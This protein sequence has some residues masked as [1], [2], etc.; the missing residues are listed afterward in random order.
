MKKITISM[1]LVISIMLSL[2]CGVAVAADSSESLQFEAD[3]NISELAASGVEDGSL[4]DPSTGKY[5][6]VRDLRSVYMGTGTPVNNMLDMRL[7]GDNSRILAN[8][9]PEDP[10]GVG[11]GVFF[12]SGFKDNYTTG[13]SISY[14]IIC[15]TK[16]GGNVSNYL[17]LTSTNRSAKG[18]EA[19]ILYYAQN[20]FCFKVFDWAQPEDARWQVDI[21]ASTL[22]SN[23]VRTKTIHGAERQFVT[24]QNTTVQVGTN[25][26]ANYVYLGTQNSYDLIYSY[27]YTATI[28]EQ[29]GQWIGSWGPIVE[30]FQ[31]TYSGTNVM[32]FYQTFLR[33]S[34]NGTWTS[35]A[36][37]TADQSYIRDDNHGFKL[38]FLDPNNGFAVDS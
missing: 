15:P 36:Y 32:G 34:N 20:D 3:P 28:D 4:Y 1:L 9:N 27:T 13:T 17:Y 2:F 35:W 29:Q 21:P 19:F 12:N 26:W 23:Y 5:L 22:L 16:P 37:L 30:T 18:V 38:V 33:S 31:D 24:V 7:K 8:E 6:P 25:R 14:D 10:G 11:Y